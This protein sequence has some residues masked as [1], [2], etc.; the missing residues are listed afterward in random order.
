[1]KLLIV[2]LGSMGKR[3]A[4]LTKGIDDAIQIIGVDTAEGRRDEAKNLGLADAAYATIAE[5]VAAEHPDAALV[6]TAP[7]SH[8]AVIGE[9]LDNDLPVF[10]ELNLVSDGYAE[11]MAKAAAKTC[12]C[13][14]P[15]RCCT[16][17]RR[18]ILNVRSLNLASLSTIS[19][20]SGSTCPTGIPGKITRISSSA[21][22]APAACG[23]FSASTCP[24]CSMPSAM[25]NPSPCRRT[26][27]S[28]LGLP[29]PDS[30]TLLL[31]H[32]GG[33]QGVLAADVVSRKAVRSFE[34]F[35]D[36]IH[37]FL[38]GQPQGAV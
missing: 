35:G 17:A 20:T 27:L 2:G 23:R 16:A 34:C 36:G 11:N 18:S 37:P 30:V 14:S 4:R 29:Y 25:W 3:R 5:A 1:M 10:T 7:L 31:R 21:T 8:A 13:F 12:R 15:R 26:P 9:L 32:K 22:P 38:G 6:C 24:G 19:T 28:D 33:V